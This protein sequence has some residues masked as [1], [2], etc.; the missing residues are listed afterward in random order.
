MF[1]F[2][3][4][5]HYSYVLFAILVVWVLAAIRLYKEYKNSL[6]NSLDSARIDKTGQTVFDLS[7]S[8]KIGLQEESDDAII[9]SLKLARRIDVLNY[10]ESLAIAYQNKSKKVRDYVEQEI[11]DRLDLDAIDRLTNSNP[12][13]KKLVEL[14]DKVTLYVKDFLTAVHD[15]SVSPDVVCACIHTLAVWYDSVACVFSI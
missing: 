5:E 15:L 8:L 9:N 11:I 12:N 3:A 2:V 10:S 4:I 14:R 1:S 13:S 7:T 6:K